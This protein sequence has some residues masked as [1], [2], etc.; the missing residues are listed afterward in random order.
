[1]NQSTLD[2]IHSTFEASK[3]GAIQFGQVIAQLIAAGVESYHVDYR[4]GRI[5][6]YLPDGSS[7]DCS[8]EKPQHGIADAFDSAAVHAAVLGAQQ[9]KV[10]Y[11]EFKQL[12]Q[13]AGCVGYTV[14][15]AGRHVSYLGRR[16]ETH[17]EHF[18]D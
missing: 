14:W 15:I 3:Q 6:F 5:T 11:P 1:M 17:V 7:T 12:T 4:A 16:G 18:P 2:T 10:Q 8:F 13:Q 9:G